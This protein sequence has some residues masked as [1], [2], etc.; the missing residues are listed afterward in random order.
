MY[1]PREGTKR[2]FVRGGPQWRFYGIR[3]AY[4]SYNPL[5]F[6]FCLTDWNSLKFSF[7]MRLRGHK[8]RKSNDHLYSFLL[9]VSSRSQYQAEVSMQKFHIMNMCLDCI[10]CLLVR[11]QSPFQGTSSSFSIVQ[12][13]P[14]GQGWWKPFSVV[15]H[16]VTYILL[17]RKTT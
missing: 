4:M 8:Q 15:L 2:T 9:S 3:G 10:F 5:Y 6:R 11:T 14:L 13:R 16:D 1:E 12:E 7:A 17:L